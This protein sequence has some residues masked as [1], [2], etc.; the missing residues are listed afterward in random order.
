MI[1]CL[2]STRCGQLTKDVE[3]FVTTLES[4]HP[5]SA[6]I[7][8]ENDSGKSVV[9]FQYYYYYY[10]YYGFTEAQTIGNEWSERKGEVR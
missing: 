10:Y 6:E 2:K 4:D 7:A 8:R 1:D 9:L 5:H 3:A